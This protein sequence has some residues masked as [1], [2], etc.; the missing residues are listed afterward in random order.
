MIIEIIPNW[1]PVLVHFT[2][3]LL[4]M[5]VFLS[6]IVT[7]IKNETLRNQLA[8]TA[9]WNLWLGV[10]ITAGTVLAGIYA[11]NTVPHHSTNQHLA[12]LDHRKWALA[13]S[14]LFLALAVWS[15]AS[16]THGQTALDS[17][18][19]YVF[20]ALMVVAGSMLLVTGYKGGELV[21]RHGIGVLAVAPPSGQPA[22]GGHT[23]HDH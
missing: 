13:T 18:R 4:A 8:V 2:I 5:S 19:H 22:D 9:R 16:Y 6:L 21:Y 11:F 14:A 15:L 3:G 10:L 12:M 7:V 1:H 23:H 17:I 20:T